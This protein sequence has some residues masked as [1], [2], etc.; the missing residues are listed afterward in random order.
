MERLALAMGLA[1]FLYYSPPVLSACCKY[2]QV[3][4][5]K[6]KNKI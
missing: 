5:D 3:S 1:A 2:D 6:T 4:E